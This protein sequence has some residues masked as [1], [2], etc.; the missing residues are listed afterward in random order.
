MKLVFIAL[1]T[2]II[3]I[4]GCTQQKVEVKENSII[5]V[6]Y[7]SS[8]LSAET[9]EKYELYENGTISVLLKSKDE[10]DVSYTETAARKGVLDMVKSVT[11]AGFF[12][13]SFSK[14]GELQDSSDNKL[15]V[16]IDGRRK[17]VS[18]Q[19]ATVTDSSTLN[20]I[21]DIIRE[22]FKVS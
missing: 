4:S 9:F 18:W 17:E 12:E 19:G 20:E 10:D 22:V 3:I 13:K 21:V 6:F 7:S 8:I 15:I 5:S 2:S 1:L 14:T 11:D 16:S